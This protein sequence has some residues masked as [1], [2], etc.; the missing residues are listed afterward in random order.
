MLAKPVEIS[1]GKS[2]LEKMGWTGGGLGK[3]GNGIV[4]PIIPK[5]AYA[6]NTLGLGHRSETVLEKKHYQN[7]DKNFHEE[8]EFK[9]NFLT[10]V[11][12]KILEFVKNSSEVDL[13]F[14]RS[15][16]NKERKKIHSI[17]EK[18]CECSDVD[19]L[20]LNKSL[21]I[22]IAS[23]ILKYNSYLLITESHGKPPERVLRLYKDVPS[24]VY[25]ITPDVL[26]DDENDEF[27]DF[28]EQLDIETEDKTDNDI[29]T[30]TEKVQYL[31]VENDKT[32]NDKQDHENMNLR[33]SVEYTTVSG[34]ESGIKNDDANVN[35]ELNLERV[36]DSKK[37]IEVTKSTSNVNYQLN[38][39]L[40]SKTESL[41]SA[42]QNNKPIEETLDVKNSNEKLYYQDLIVEQESK[43][44]VQI[45]NSEIKLNIEMNSQRNSKKSLLGVI[46]DYFTE[47]V[48]DTS[49]LEFRFLG[50]FNSEEF[51]AIETFFDICLKRDK[52]NNKEKIEL[53]Q[54]L[55]SELY[56]F[57]FKED[58]NGSIV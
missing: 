21:D 28:C 56:N 12:S 7:K 40:H 15:L 53:L 55:N 34:E 32:N 35:Y 11:L 13:L 41:E 25:L 9:H 46:I 10:N 23:E 50:S 19:E 31:E 2:L 14:E 22:K 48:V 24:Y 49:F 4:N 30:F 18:L 43:N 58:L 57:E 17:V 20:N 26:R 16:H 6:M 39:E 45:E 44:I 51:N 37:A 3:D 5:A 47:F 1:K 27:D 33:S 54:L 29:A 42:L 38:C 52:E 8:L 36:S